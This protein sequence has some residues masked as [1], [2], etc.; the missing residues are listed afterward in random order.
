MSILHLIR[1][2]ASHTVSFSG[3]FGNEL[4]NDGRS[5][6]SSEVSQFS[7]QEDVV[8]GG[9]WQKEAINFSF[10]F[11]GV[12]EFFYPDYPQ[13]QSQKRLFPRHKL[14]IMR[15][16]GKIFQSTKKIHFCF[17]L[18]Y[19]QRNFSFIPVYLIFSAD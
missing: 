6:V 4:S 11:C 15:E 13:T 7:L 19:R 14:F 17:L 16:M 10:R 9:E 5:I 2:L 12:E 8:Y 18:Q 3:F 1:L